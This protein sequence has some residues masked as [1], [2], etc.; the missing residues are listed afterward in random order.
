MKWHKLSSNP[1]SLERIY[2][3]VPKLESLELFSINLDREGSNIQISFDLPRFPEHPPKRWH[4]DFNTVQI[5]LTF[6]SVAD[7][8]AKGWRNNMTVN[9]E[10]EKNK[11]LL[12]VFLSN[13][14]IDLMFS[15]LCEMFRIDNISAYQTSIKN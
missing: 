2:D 13:P 5:K 1:Q 6:Y 14:E 3:D 4:R 11:N 10:I 9:I 15:F 8:Q 12:K 7:F